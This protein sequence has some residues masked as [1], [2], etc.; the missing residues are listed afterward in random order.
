ME[1]GS[2]PNATSP[3]KKSTV[4][5]RQKHDARATKK[6]HPRNKIEILRLD[7]AS[8]PCSRKSQLGFYLLPH[9]CHFTKM[10][11]NGSFQPQNLKFV[12]REVRLASDDASDT[13][14][15]RPSQH[16]KAH[17][18]AGTTRTGTAQSGTQRAW[19]KEHPLPQRSTLRQIVPRIPHGA[20]RPSHAPS[21]QTKNSPQPIRPRGDSK[22]HF[23]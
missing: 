20:T 21:A 7:F 1:R 8:W 13:R 15:S 16:A 4:P 22:A 3:R 6:R 17:D 12:A 9:E 11:S 14:I 23:N 19:A 5:M 10:D 18:P 2:R